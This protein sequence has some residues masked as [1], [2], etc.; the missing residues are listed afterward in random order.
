MTDTP[1]QPGT[2]APPAAS[3][4][5]SDSRRKRRGTGPFL[6]AEQEIAQAQEAARARNPAPVAALTN[7]RPLTPKFGR[8]ERADFE[9]VESMLGSFATR[10]FG[11]FV[12]QVMNGFFGGATPAE[13]NNADLRRAA[14]TFCLYGYRDPKGVRLVDMFTSAGVPLEGRQRAALDACLQARLLLVAVDDVNP[15]KQRVRGKDLLR[16]EPVTLTDSNLSQAL[17][18]GDRVL[19][20]SIPWGTSWQPIGVGQ[21]LEARRAVVLDRGLEQLCD[22]LR[23]VKRELPDR[24]GPNLF[25]LVHRIANAPIG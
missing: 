17:R 19:T 1:E 21:R 15:G 5:R 18:P 22:S 4:P 24:H 12:T 8:Y 25:W 7:E 3:T 13:K 20:W 10:R 14:Q 23:A 6:T 11:P 16:D 9:R 2:V